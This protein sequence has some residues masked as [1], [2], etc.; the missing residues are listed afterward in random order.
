MWIIFVQ[1]IREFWLGFTYPWQ[2]AVLLTKNPRLLPYLVFPLLLNLCL[3]VALYGGLLLPGWGWIETVVNNVPRELEVLLETA[4][5]LLLGLLLLLATGFLIGQFG[6]I[7]GAPWYG[8]LSEQ[9]EQLQTDSVPTLESSLARIIQDLG[10]ALLFEAKKLLVIVVIGIP[11]LLLNL[12]P[13]AGTVLA[14]VG[15]FVLF[16][17]VTGLSFVDP[18]LER[19]RLGFRQ[20]VAHFTQMGPA[21]WSFSLVS[22]GLLNIPLLN[23]LVVPILITAGTLLYCEKFLKNQ[24]ASSS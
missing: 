24:L 8:Q 14:S 20:K 22:F 13:I 4:L 10:R 15:G 6:V 17:W 1:W 3:G 5:R 11:L 12:L 23:L 7:L 18:P 16:A 9:V 2:G 21:G 19:R